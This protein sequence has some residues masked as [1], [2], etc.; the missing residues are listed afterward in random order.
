MYREIQDHWIYR[1]PLW[2]RWWS[3]M[4]FWASYKNSK[5][6]VRKQVVEL[7]RGQLCGSISYFTKA[8][9]T[10]KEQVIDFLK[11]LQSEGMIEK[12]TDRNITIVT[13]C[14]YESYQGAVRSNSDSLSDSESDSKS[15]NTSDNNPDNMS[16]NNP[17][18]NKEIKEIKEDNIIITTTP[19]AHTCEENVEWDDVREDGYLESFKAHGKARDAMRLTRKSLPEVME[20]LEVYRAK[21]RMQ[22]RGHK[23]YNQ[24]CNLFAWYLEHGK[25]PE[26]QQPQQVQQPKQKKVITN[27]DIYREMKEMGWES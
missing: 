20:L 3:D 6:L 11:L 13:I 26:P 4:L 22:N 12:K 17:D 1:N 16:D 14:N 25:L 18:T 24:F 5:I 27:A 23:D 9:A 2:Y 8:W 10:T 7:K 19:R 21:R 15:E